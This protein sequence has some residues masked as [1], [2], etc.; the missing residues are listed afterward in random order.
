M[1][2]AV[3]LCR[4]FRDPCIFPGASSTGVLL[5]RS[6]QLRGIAVKIA[7]APARARAPEGI[8]F[9]LARVFTF[10]ARILVLMIAI[11][12]LYGLWRQSCI[13]IDFIDIKKYMYVVFNPEIV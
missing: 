8:L 7:L 2:D 12:A 6:R 9:D 3:A 4:L 13:Y 5:R 11:K 10:A 1:Q